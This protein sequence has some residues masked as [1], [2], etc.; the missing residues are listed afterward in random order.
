MRSA[1][2]EAKRALARAEVLVHKYYEPTARERDHKAT[3][4]QGHVLVAHQN[5]KM[6]LEELE[7]DQ[8][9]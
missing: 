5:L 9:R 2:A 6:A 8:A 1:I 3:P 7:D 4:V